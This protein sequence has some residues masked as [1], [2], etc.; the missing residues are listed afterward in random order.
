[1]TGRSLLAGVVAALAG[2]GVFAGLEFA[3][4]V[5]YQRLLGGAIPGLIVIMVVFGA[6]GA[7]AGWLLALLIYSGMRGEGFGEGGGG[8]TPEDF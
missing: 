8:A 3:G 5:V 2:V 6:L 4:M 1:M 7:Y